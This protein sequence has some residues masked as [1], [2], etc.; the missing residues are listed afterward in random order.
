MKKTFLV[1]AVAMTIFSAGFVSAGEKEGGWTPTAEVAI[2]IHSRQVDGSGALFYDRAVSNQAVTLGL[3]K[4]GTG[5]YIQAE[6]FAPLE[7]EENREIDFYVGFYTEIVGMKFDAGYGHF[8]V[9]ESGELDYHAA[10]LGIDFPE[11]GWQ[12]VPFV[13]TEY[14]FAKGS[15]E[16]S[17]D[18]FMYYGGFKREFQI[19]ERVGLVAELGIGGNTGVYG[20]PAENLAYAREKVEISIFLA[21]QWKLK[22]T[23]LTQQNL[24]QT[25]GIA[26]DTDRLFASAVIIWTF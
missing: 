6:N 1:V 9:R 3:D 15:P 21:K 7:K 2:G 24:G 10:Y 22:L 23:G 12:I 4:K 25:E 13:K 26:A 20:M 11:I 8:W 17:M 18:G 5:L 16:V 14:D 19:H